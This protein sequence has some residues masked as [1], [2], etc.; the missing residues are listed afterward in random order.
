[1][2]GQAG[3]ARLAGWPQKIEEAAHG[4]AG[5]F[6]YRPLDVQKTI[7]TVH[8]L[9]KQKMSQ[10]IENI[11]HKPCKKIR[12]A[13]PQTDGSFYYTVDTFRMC[14]DGVWELNS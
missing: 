3:Q 1:M 4:R 2:Q 10:S 7:K 12:H 14:A 9:A 6:D 13:I 8:V 5:T 11:A